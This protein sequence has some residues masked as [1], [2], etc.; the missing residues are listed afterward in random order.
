M[1]A[2]FPPGPQKHFIAGNAPQFANDPFRFLTESPRQYGELVHFRF[3]PTHA[4]LVNNPRQAHYVLVEAPERFTDR[5][6]YLKTLN[7]AMGHDLFPPKDQL[8]RNQRPQLGYDPRWLCDFAEQIASAITMLDWQP[9]AIPDVPAALKAM[10]ARMTARLL[11]ERDELPA[12]LSQ[13]IPY[14]RPMAD[15]RFESPLLPAWLPVGANRHRA[16]ARAALDKQIAALRADQRCGLFA[17]LLYAAEGQAVDE[18]LLLSYAGSEIVANTLAWA[19]RLL[20]T[21][22]EEAAELRQEIMTVLNGRLP[23]APDLA[24]LPYTEMV[25]RETLR[26]YPPVWVITRQ[27]TREAQIGNYYVP[28]GSAVFVSPYALHHNPKQFINSGSFY[29]GRFAPGYERR[30]NRYSY[31]PFG[32][33]ARAQMEESFVVTVSTLLLA[34]I[35]GRY[36]LEAG[37]PP[38]IK[39]G[40]TLA[41]TPFTLRVATSSNDCSPYPTTTPVALPDYTMVG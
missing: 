30:F 39:P 15:R 10:T 4:Y 26:L 7:S 12:E 31:M 18:M 1:D 6:N 33:G 23:A 14:S 34:V 2:F 40:L 41:P 5:P 35:A 13:G 36:D 11:F 27:A 9:G 22:P 19:L 21:H 29:P 37:A 24:H 17:R 38:E 25:I 20:A 28:A 16:A 32:A 8:G 3:G